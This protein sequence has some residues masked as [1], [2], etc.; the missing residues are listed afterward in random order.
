M[1]KS[2]LVCLFI[3]LL[4]CP[5]FALTISVVPSDKF[6]PGTD[7]WNLLA[8]QLQ[9]DT[10]IFYV[11][12]K[13]Y[14][15]TVNVN[16]LPGYSGAGSLSTTYA[17]NGDF[18][19]YYV[20][21]DPAST[22]PAPVTLNFTIN[23]SET[24]LGVIFRESQLVSSN[25]LFG[26]PSGVTYRSLTSGNWGLESNDTITVTNNT[27]SFSLSSPLYAD[28]FRIITAVPAVPPP[29][30]GAPGTTQSVPEPGTMLLLG[31]GL[32]GLAG[33]RKFKK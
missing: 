10:T 6:D 30:I 22:G 3:L 18:K 27:V 16:A 5:S 7:S 19:S 33:F 1:K 26:V 31:S 25:S 28:D 11:E 13:A 23:S 24:I 29:N 4:S 17:L 8:D 12:E 9:S 14:T 2:L 21:F 32:I 20:H 15:G